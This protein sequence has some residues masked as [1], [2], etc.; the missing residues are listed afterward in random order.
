M[1]EGGEGEGGGR[2]GGGIFVDKEGGTIHQG[3]A[4]EV[5]AGRVYEGD[6]HLYKLHMW[7]SKC[8]ILIF[9]LAHTGAKF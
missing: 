2:G 7:K 4:F 3:I 9:N 8:E 1:N 5:G 6:F